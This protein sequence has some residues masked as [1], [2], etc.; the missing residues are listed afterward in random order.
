MT[1][2]TDIHPVKKPAQIYPK[3]F[4]ISEQADKRIEKQPSNRP[5]GGSNGV[6]LRACMWPPV[7]GS[8]VISI[9][10]RPHGL[11]D[12]QTDRVQRAM[13]LTA[14]IEAT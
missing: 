5:N 7:P 13:R 3:I 9:K 8:W 4:S 2:R 14:V 6:L 12:R 11:T 10:P 1:K